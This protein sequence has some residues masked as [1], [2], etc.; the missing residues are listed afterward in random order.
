MPLL[1]PKGRLSGNY[2]Y[3]F[4]F[5]II[6]VKFQKD[7]KFDYLL[8]SPYGICSAAH[9]KRRCLLLHF[10]LVNE[11]AR[12]ADSLVGFLASVNLRL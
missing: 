2:S 5:L 6:K 12:L 4:S 7:A 10:S 11:A 8:S 3:N 9:G 1:A